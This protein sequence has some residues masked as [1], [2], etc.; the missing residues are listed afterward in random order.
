MGGREI[1]TEVHR[2][3]GGFLPKKVVGRDWDFFLKAKTSD[4]DIDQAFLGGIP[5]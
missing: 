1:E 5:I 3:D 2:A 4:V